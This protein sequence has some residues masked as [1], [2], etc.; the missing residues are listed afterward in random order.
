MVGTEL[1]KHRIDLLNDNTKLT[2]SDPN[3]TVLTTT[4]FTLPKTGRII[5]EKKIEPAATEWSVSIVL[6]IKT[7]DIFCFRV[8]YQKLDA[9]ITCYLYFFRRMV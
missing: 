5:S 8:D 7:D 9:V 6:A 3:R 2:H 1:S 4:K